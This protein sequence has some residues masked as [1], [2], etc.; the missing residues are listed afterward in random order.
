MA[1]SGVM[2]NDDAIDPPSPEEGP[3]NEAKVGLLV[4]AAPRL[5]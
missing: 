4:H 5:F 1:D 3:I 2:P